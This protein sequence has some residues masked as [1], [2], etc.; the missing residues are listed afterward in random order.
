MSR[1]EQIGDVIEDIA[2]YLPEGEELT[3]AEAGIGVHVFFCLFVCLFVCLFFIF[4]FL[5][6]LF[7]VYVFCCFFFVCLFVF[8]F[9]LFCFVFV[10]L[11]VFCFLLLFVFVFVFFFFSMLLLV[12]HLARGSWHVINCIRQDNATVT[13]C[14]YLKKCW[15]KRSH[16]VLRDIRWRYN[17]EMI[18][19]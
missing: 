13:L 16:L 9:C 14:C 3:I 10:C 5:F 19:W 7:F 2:S 12:L 15:I 18:W 17:I 1:I 8:C 11:L 6:L 4:C